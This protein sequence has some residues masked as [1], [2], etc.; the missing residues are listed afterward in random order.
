[1]MPSI[2]KRDANTK[3]FFDLYDAKEKHGVETNVR[4]LC[5]LYIPVG[6]GV[7]MRSVVANSIYDSVYP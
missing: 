5:C 1:M 2:Q 6:A 7:R 4:R 3:N